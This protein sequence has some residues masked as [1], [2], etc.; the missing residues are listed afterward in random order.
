[1]LTQQGRQRKEVLH[2]T[3]RG[4][5]APPDPPQIS[6][7]FSEPEQNEPGECDVCTGFLDWPMTPIVEWPESERERFFDELLASY[8]ED[9]Q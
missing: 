1:M 6:P 7:V 4:S 3:R 9:S 2:S 5:A 8:P